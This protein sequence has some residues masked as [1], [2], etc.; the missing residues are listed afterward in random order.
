MKRGILYV[1]LICLLVFIGI[2]NKEDSYF[3]AATVMGAV[4]LCLI[5][6]LI[7]KAAGTEI[8][9]NMNIPVVE[10]STEFR[11]WLTVKTRY[12]QAPFVSASFYVV[13]AGMKRKRSSSFLKTGAHTGSCYGNMKL[14]VSGRYEIKAENVRIYDA[15]HLFYFKKKVDKSAYIDV[16]PECY[17]MPINVNKKTRD[18]VTDSDVYYSD[19]RGDDASEVYQ[20]RQYR[21]GASIKSIHWK[22]SARQD[23]IMAKDTSKTMSCPVIICV[24]MDG[25][26]CKHY[27]KALS[28]CLESMVSISFSLITVRVPHFIAWYDPKQMSIT[29]YRITRVEDVYDAAARLSYVD[30]RTSDRYDIIGLYRERYKGED[31]TSFIDIDMQGSITCGNDSFTVSYGSLKEELAN[32]YITV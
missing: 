25:K 28:A 5:A 22:L 15:L 31:F 11:P 1:A 21:P 14:S 6:G 29:R 26:L 32:I 16:L 18:F 30:A 19:V 27:G 3:Y 13:A 2:L 7:I 8:K 10:K 4:M 12:G 20:I 17:L 24:N 9:M 23:E